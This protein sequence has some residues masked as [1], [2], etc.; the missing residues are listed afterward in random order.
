MYLG[1]IARETMEAIAA[2]IMTWDGDVAVVEGDF[3]D[4]IDG[5]GYENL[6]EALA[7]AAYATHGA[8]NEGGLHA[9]AGRIAKRFNLSAGNAV[10]ITGAWHDLDGSGCVTCVADALEKIGCVATISELAPASD[11]ETARW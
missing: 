7:G 9:A 8:P 6:R 4:E 11:A 10:R 2:E 5:R 1:S 3:M